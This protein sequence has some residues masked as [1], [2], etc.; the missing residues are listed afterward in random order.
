MQLIGNIYYY[1]LYKF[2]SI[3][4]IAFYSYHHCIV[5][6]SDLYRNSCHTSTGIVATST[7]GRGVTNLLT[8][9][10]SSTNKR[11]VAQ[12]VHHELQNIDSKC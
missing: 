11:F 6:G 9:Q 2:D 5:L 1:T 4:V 7:V 12:D 3:H 10:R 8:A